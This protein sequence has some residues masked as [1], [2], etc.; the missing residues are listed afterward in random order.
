MT[1]DR[2]KLTNNHWSFS[3]EE[4]RA[5][6]GLAGLRFVNDFTALALSVPHLPP[7]E[8]VAVGGGEAV[9]E[10]T[11]AV[12][13][14]GTGLGVSGLV[15][16]GAGW[17]ALQGEGGH[18]TVGVVTDRERAVRDLP[19]HA[20]PARLGRAVPV[21]TRARQ[22]R[23]RAAASSTVS[24]R[25]CCFR[26]TSRASAR[27]ARTRMCEE[28]LGIFCRLLG[29]CA[30]NLALT[31]GAEGG[32]VIGGGIVPRLGD[33]FARSEFRAAFEAKGRMAGL[34]RA[35]PDARHPLAVPGA[36]RRG[37]TARLTRAARGAARLGDAR[38]SRH[39]TLGPRRSAAFRPI[40]D[41]SSGRA[42]RRRPHERAL[43]AS[44]EPCFSSTSAAAARPSSLRRIARMRAVTS[45]GVRADV[46]D[47][48]GVVAERASR[49]RR[50]RRAR[51]P[52]SSGIH[53]RTKRQSRVL[54]EELLVRAVDAQRV[55]ADDACL[56][57]HLRV[58]D[59]GLEVAEQARQRVLDRAPGQLAARSRRWSRAS[60]ACGS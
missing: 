60:R 6:L 54:I 30:G 1:G 43:G 50:S 46:G 27:A 14:P 22:H 10:R 40:R 31:L 18:V 16:C 13:G 55:D 19:R 24:S 59:A 36:H 53:S 23:R 33:F 5:E 2:I 9:P 51:T 4:T 49:R 39:G 47:R 12:I 21:G 48:R 15:P 38:H 56:H 20:F 7:G 17:S 32:V 57:L 29:S 34:P 25:G 37:P 8:L 45:R 35:H 3:I 58:V 42:G 44:R 26:P 41:S 52:A 11:I 28:T